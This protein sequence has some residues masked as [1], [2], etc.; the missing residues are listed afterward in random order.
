MSETKRTVSIQLLE[1]TYHVDSPVDQIATLQE[2][3]L[4]LDDKL[5]LCAQQMKKT[6]AQRL[7]LMTALNLSHELLLAKKQAGENT[8][9]L[10]ERVRTLQ[11][12]LD[13]T[14]TKQQE[15]EL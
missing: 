10:S 14:I 5:A 1:K 8:K 12:K 15:I 7:I 9:I 6:N 2:A 13:E 4:Y 11:N 3:A